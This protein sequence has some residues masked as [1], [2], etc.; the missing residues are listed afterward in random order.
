M[1]VDLYDAL[2]TNRPYRKALP[3]EQAFDIMRAETVKGLWDPG[4]M[5]EFIHMVKNN[6]V[7]KLSHP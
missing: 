3:E 6:M 5:H 7:D 2:T 4:L 1:T